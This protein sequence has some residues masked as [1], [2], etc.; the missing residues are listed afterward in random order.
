LFEADRL[1]N[2]GQIVLVDSYFDK[3]I[4]GYIDKPG[5]EWLIAPTDPYYPIAVHLAKVDL[6][7]LPDADAV[8]FFEVT[9]S[10]WRSFLDAR[11][12]TLDSDPEFLGSFKLQP[13]LLEST[14]AYCEKRGATFVLC[15]QSRGTPESAA[16]ALRLTL[17]SR[18]RL[19]L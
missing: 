9:E 17:N 1:R 15:Q 3:L 5:I 2:S 12:R 16:D 4:A 14:R 7:A 8:V 19:T 6:E 10:T 13:S 11:G 18:F